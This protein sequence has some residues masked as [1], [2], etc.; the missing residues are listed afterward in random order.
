VKI[1]SHIAILPVFLGISWAQAKNIEW[2]PW[3]DSVFDQAKQKGRFVLLDLGTGWCHWCHVMDEITYRDPAVVDLIQKRYVAV[4]V[5]ADSRPDLANRYEDYGWPATI[6]F[7]VDRSE[8]VKPKAIFPPKPMASMLQAIIDDLSPGPSVLPEYKLASVDQAV[9]SC[10]SRNRL[11][12][13]LAESYDQKNKG[14][15][16][17]QKFLNWDIIEYCMVEAAQG[18]TAFERMGRETFAAQLNLIDPVWG[19]VCQYSTDGDWRHPH[20][21]KIMQTQAEDLRIYAKAFAFWND[22]SY[23]AT[24]EKIHRYLV[25]FL[26]SD[27]GASYASQDADLVPGE[28]SAGYYQLNDAE[29]RK[30]GIP[31][32]DEHLYAR[33]NG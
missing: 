14:W 8:I 27:T 26:V 24:A 22:P 3:S 18:N 1:L 4:R 9:L 17:V 33:E 7:N 12:Q 31:A 6:V 5:D 2:Q 21:E 29:R 28:H 16:T 10:G 19:G 15:G 25:Q 11:R 30:C 32:I 23:L 13:R 20:F